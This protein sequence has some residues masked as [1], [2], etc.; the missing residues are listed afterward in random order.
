GLVEVDHGDGAALGGQ[1]YGGGGAD[2]ARGTGDDRDPLLS[3][4]HCC[5]SSPLGCG[6]SGPAQQVSDRLVPSADVT[7]EALA[8]GVN[9]TPGLC[10]PLPPAAAPHPLRPGGRPP[11]PASRP[12]S[13]TGTRSAHGCAPGGRGAPS[14]GG[15]A[16]RGR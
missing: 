6:S 12:P 15:R 14:V 1:S 5:F 4:G 11:R 13:G 16:I 7:L 9:G 10:D 3:G 2:A 8:R